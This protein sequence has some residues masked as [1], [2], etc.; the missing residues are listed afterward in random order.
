MFICNAGKNS[1]ISLYT[2]DDVFVA[3]IK[4]GVDYQTIVAASYSS[5][6]GAD[7]SLLTENDLVDFIANTTVSVDAY[8][9]GLDKKPDPK[10]MISGLLDLCVIADR[11][12][13]CLLFKS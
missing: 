9:S 10:E 3:E 12:Y 5:G 11:N 4:A 13:N 7:L 1:R 2:K 6:N 8:W